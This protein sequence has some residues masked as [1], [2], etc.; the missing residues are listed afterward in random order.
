VSQTNLGFPVVAQVPNRFGT[1]TTTG[2]ATGPIVGLTASN[3][4]YANQIFSAFTDFGTPAAGGIPARP[5]YSGV[6]GSTGELLI[7][8]QV[9]TPANLTGN[10]N[11]DLLGAITTPFRRFESI[12]FDQFGYFSQSV[13]LT[14]ASASSTTGGTSTTFTVTD[15]PDYGGSLFVSDLASGLYVTVTPLA[16][17]PSN[18]LTPIQVPVQGSGI[19][20]VT[21][22]AA[23]NVIP[24]ITNGNT[25]SG[26]NVGGRIIRILPDGT[27]NTFAYGF[28]TNGAQDSTSFINSMR[29]RSRAS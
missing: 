11:T 13:T 19:I 6:Q 24:I 20:G 8:N 15:P 17:L 14:S 4:D 1:I 26:T 22:D 7:G 3:S 27:L 2:V 12:A 16:P 10:G 9:V 28:N 18:L 23:G 25:T 5:G 29:T 21:T